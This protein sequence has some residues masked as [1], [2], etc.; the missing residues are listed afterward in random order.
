MQLVESEIIYRENSCILFI[1]QELHQLGEGYTVD[2]CVEERVSN[3]SR[4]LRNA[5]IR[6]AGVYESPQRNL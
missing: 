4:R 5:I 3:S 6:E 2:E 1:F